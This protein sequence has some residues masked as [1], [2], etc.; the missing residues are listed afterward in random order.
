MHLGG[1]AVEA[2]AFGVALVVVDAF[3]LHLIAGERL[4]A[5]PALD[6]VAQRKL[7]I[8]LYL[9]IA[10]RV[11]SLQ[12]VHPKEHVTRHQWLVPSLYHLILLQQSMG[13]KAAVKRVSEYLAQGLVIER[14]SLL[15]E[16][17][18]DR[19]VTQ[20]LLSLQLE[21]QPNK[22]ARLVWLYHLLSVHLVLVVA[23]GSL[24][25][26][27]VA[28]PGLG[29]HACRTALPP[30]VVLHVSHGEVKLLHEHTHR[31]GRIHR[32]RHCQQRDAR[33]PQSVSDK[34][35]TC[36][37]AGETVMA[38][39]DDIANLMAALLNKVEH[40]LKLFPLV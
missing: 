9:G 38:I 6:V 11:L 40:L 18:D 7:L 17:L 23:H 28:F 34:G 5:G 29:Y 16:P 8:F 13:D 26:Y 36:S 30:L 22:L 33:L 19:R 25:A 4:L 2:A 32:L 15:L 3:L 14:E 27:P 1:I 37:G 31:R 35:G 10:L 24:S 12:P 39:D 20:S 21:G